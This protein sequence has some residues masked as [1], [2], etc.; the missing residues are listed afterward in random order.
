ML[1]LPK[2][3][4]QRLTQTHDT[5]CLSAE[6]L[7][8]KAS[9]LLATQK[10]HAAQHRR[11]R[12]RRRLPSPSFS[13]STTR[14]HPR[15]PSLHPS[16]SRGGCGGARPRPRPRRPGPRSPAPASSEL[17]G[18]LRLPWRG[19][20]GSGIQ[21]TSS[22]S[23]GR[24]PA[25]GAARLG[26]VLRELRRLFLRSLLE[27]G[28]FGCGFL[29]LRVTQ[30]VKFGSALLETVLDTVKIKKINRSV[31]FNDTSEVNLYT[32]S[33]NSCWTI[34]EHHILLAITRFEI[35]LVFIT[36]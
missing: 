17:D 9:P 34:T 10:R 19:G 36:D 8:K 7:R 23:G 11:P 32:N 18:A 27:F 29:L 33:L 21:T 3:N 28:I 26:G 1:C 12:P 25:A 22:I 4:L 13:S 35:D 14:Q 5:F 20:F 30:T 16:A 31:N 6:T 24:G 2:N 15:A